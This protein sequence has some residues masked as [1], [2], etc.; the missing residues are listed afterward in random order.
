MNSTNIGQVDN[1]NFLG[2]TSNK[3]LN[4]ASHIDALIPNYHKI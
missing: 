1:L 3:C 4:W 2:K